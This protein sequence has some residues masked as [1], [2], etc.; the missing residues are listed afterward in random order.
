[1]PTANSNGLFNSSRVSPTSSIPNKGCYEAMNLIVADPTAQSEIIAARKASG[2]DRY[3]EVWEGV[4]VIMPI[5]NDEHQDIVGQLTTVLTAVIQWKKLGL[6]RPGVNVSDRVEHWTDNYRCPDVVVYL[7]GTSAENHGAFWRGGP[8]LG[9]EI[10][11]E[12]DRS[13]EKLDFYASVQTRE[14]LIIDR[15]PWALELY[16]LTGEE[17]KLAGRSDLESAAVVTSEVVPLSWRLVPGEE[18]P[19]IEITHADGRQ[20][21]TV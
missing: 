13:R 19:R 21:W 16:R 4:Y 18:R 1:M 20:Q 8:D 2:L 15:E 14:V 6:V 17:M 7:N 5:A 11:S 12:G 10:V 9:I 3:D